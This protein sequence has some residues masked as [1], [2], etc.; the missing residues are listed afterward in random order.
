MRVFWIIIGLLG[1]AT[2]LALW[3]QTMSAEAPSISVARSP[4]SPSSSPDQ[5]RDLAA[6]LLA[7]AESRR[8]SETAGSGGPARPP[9]FAD[10]TPLDP[11]PFVRDSL[12]AFPAD[13]V[14][15]VRIARLGDGSL[16]LDDRFVV[17]GS[18]TAVDPYRI[19]WDLLI[20]ASE[21][22]MPR[23]GQ[24]RLPQRVTMLHDKHVRLTGHIMLPMYADNPRELLVML[25]QWDGCCIG[26]PPSPYDAVEVKL[27]APLSMMRQHLSP[28]ATIEG[29]L[30]VDPYVM[31]TWLVGLYLLENGTMKLEL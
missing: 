9:A 19:T 11:E 26:V 20:S 4:S 21:T 2:G 15:P 22:Y 6:E 31:D 24:L 14:V 3:R 7:S 1:L 27:A 8:Q 10:A 13:Q 29:R 25:N 5:L 18:G 23:L 17:K 16:V 30:Q 12:A 28:L